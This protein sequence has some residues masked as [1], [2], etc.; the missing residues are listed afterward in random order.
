[1]ASLQWHHACAMAMDAEAVDQA[2]QDLG[3]SIANSDLTSGYIF[4]LANPTKKLAGESLS[5][6]ISW[7]PVRLDGYLVEVRSKEPII[8]N[9]RSRAE[10]VSAVLKKSL[11]KLLCKG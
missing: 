1:M 8:S 5:V 4:A 7:S 2:L 6:L 10:Q 11:A 9:K 3:F